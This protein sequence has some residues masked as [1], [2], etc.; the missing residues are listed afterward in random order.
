MQRSSYCEVPGNSRFIYNATPAPK[1]QET[2]RNRRQEECK[3][4]TSTVRRYFWEQQEICSH[5][6]STVWLPKQDLDMGELEERITG[7]VRGRKGKLA[8]NYVIVL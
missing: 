5:D 1:I 6:T 8:R 7:W 2:V 3:G 4:K